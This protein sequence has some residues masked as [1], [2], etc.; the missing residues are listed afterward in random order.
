MPI[1]KLKLTNLGPFDEVEFEFD[2][3]VNV[4]VGPNNC[5]KS[6]A[7]IALADILVRS[8]DL[9]H[10][11]FRVK[12]PEYGF[13]WRSQPVETPAK[14][15][16]VN[17]RHRTGQFGRKSRHLCVKGYNLFI[18]ALRSS[19]DFRSAG[20][21]QGTVRKLPEHEE[22]SHAA[23]IARKTVSARPQNPYRTSLVRDAPILQKII[24]LDYRAYRQDK[25]AMRQIVSK[26]ASIASQITEG[27]PIKF[28]GVAE[29]GRGLYL[30]FE[31]PDGKVPLD[32]LSQGTQS[33]I[34]WLGRLLLGYAKR[35]DFPSMFD[36]KPGI[37]II[38]EID[39]HLHPSWQRRIIPAITKEF[40]S[41]QIFCSTHSPLMLAGLK[42]GQIHLLKRD[43]KG[44]VTVSRNETDI[45]G[46]SADEIV[47]TFLGVE[48]AT[49]FQTEQDIKRL[50]ELRD[51]KR[52]STKQREELER[53]RGTVN[54]ALLSGAWIDDVEGLAARLATP[55]GKKTPKKAAKK[56]PTSRKK[57]SSRPSKRTIPSSKKR[58]KK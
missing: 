1:S 25:P 52:L 30:Q 6:T 18:P 57:T 58:A 4:L 51:K 15:K 5:G 22:L 42:A 10:K 38:D 47:T 17:M 36:G 11:L 32:V 19:T 7:L 21:G 44:K 27:F 45:I 53:L 20:P 12:S 33:L 56:K 8:F 31:T 39:A 13:T 48:S 23:K 46:W 49:D 50:Q 37:L 35:Y 41:L 34:Q 24:D 26:V 9:P 40:P 43:K 54:R 3:Q 14:A 28:V 29:D 55:Q 2:P 16:Q